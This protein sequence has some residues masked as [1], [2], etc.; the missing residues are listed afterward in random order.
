MKTRFLLLC[1]IA[2]SAIAADSATLKIEVIGNNWEASHNDIRPLL[3]SAAHELWTQFPE[4]S[5]PPIRVSRS[6]DGPIVLY[7]RAAGGAY[8]V[9]LDTHSTYWAQYSYQFAHEFCHI[10]CNYRPEN[11]PNKWFEEA[12]CEL[13]SLYCLRAMAKT[14]KTNAPYSNW[15]SFAP[16]LHSYAQDRIDNTDKPTDLAAWYKTNQSKLRGSATIRP[17]NN[18]VAV[19]ILPLVEAEPA[20]WRAVAYLNAARA[21]PGQSFAE[22]L[23]N[24]HTLT[25]TAH[26][27][28]VAEIAKRF[29]YSVG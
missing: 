28:F 18:V 13:A 29:G 7:D 1:L 16:K 26:Q 15:R 6:Y 8:Q 17:L 4:Q 27:P 22:Y 14:W 9:K 12:L 3:R 23:R 24:W 21:Y 11:H 20:H 25:P 2:N 10:L 19:N 5:L